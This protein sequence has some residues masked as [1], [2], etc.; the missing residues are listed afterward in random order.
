MTL[1]GDEE[2]IYIVIVQINSKYYT[3]TKH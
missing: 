1:W 2:D 3:A